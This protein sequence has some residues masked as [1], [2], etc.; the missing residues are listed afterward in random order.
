MTTNVNDGNSKELLKQITGYLVTE[1]G[2]TDPKVNNI[3][4][5]S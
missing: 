3:N 4:Q 1:L 2:I 5:Y